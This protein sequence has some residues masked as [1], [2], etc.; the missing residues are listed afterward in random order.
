MGEPAVQLI[1]QS[2]KN[3]TQDIR[4]M[5]KEIDK[6]KGDVSDVKSNQQLT[7]QNV[8]HILETLSDLKSNFKELDVKL[9]SDKDEQLRK[10]KS[11]IW[12]VAA[13]IIIAFILVSLGLR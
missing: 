10:Y 3:N 7:N 12:Q 13:A 6:L 8:S 9:D 11:M 1:E 4:E 2:V 5:K